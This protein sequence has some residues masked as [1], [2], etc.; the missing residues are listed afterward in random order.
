MVLA[1]LLVIFSMTVVINGQ[2]SNELPSNNDTDAPT[3]DDYAEP[4][5]AIETQQSKNEDVATIP[6]AY[7]TTCPS[8][9]QNSCKKVNIISDFY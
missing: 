3:E 7:H 8:G 2:L 4:M 1:H 9:G 6:A 5:E